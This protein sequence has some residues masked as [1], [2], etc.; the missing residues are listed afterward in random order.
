MC[1]NLELFDIKRDS[2]AI[3]SKFDEETVFVFEV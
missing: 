3:V 1:C 2:D